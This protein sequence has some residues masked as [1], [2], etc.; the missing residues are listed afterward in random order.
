MLKRYQP[1]PGVVVPDLDGKPIR[2]P[3]VVD[4]ADSYYKR[5]IKDGDLVA[6]TRPKSPQPQ[7]T[8]KDAE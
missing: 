1:A 6:F 7:K 8:K 5:R 4:T 2:G 3:I